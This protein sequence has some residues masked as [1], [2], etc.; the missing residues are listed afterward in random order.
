MDDA[1]LG[2]QLGAAK[3]GA[4][5][6]RPTLKFA[7]AGAV[8]YA[9]YDANPAPSM[10]M[11]NAGAYANPN[12]QLWRGGAQWLGSQPT[13]PY[14]AQAA[15]T[16]PGGV[17]ANI[18]ALPAN[19]KTWYNQQNANA[20]SGGGGGSG[21][22][23]YYNPASA[24]SAPAA[25]PAAAA[26]A[27]AAPAPAPIVAPTSQNIVAPTSTTTVSDPTTTTTGAP[28]LPNSIQAKSYDPNVDATTGAGFANTSNTGGTNYSVGKGDK[29]KQNSA[30]QISG[31]GD[32]ILSRKGGSIT[33]R[34]NRYD[35]GGDVG[36]SAVGMPPG[37]GGQGAIP[38]IY[39]NPATYAG[40]GAPIGKGISQNSVGTTPAGAI[41]SLPMA[42]GGSVAFADGGDVDEYS[43]MPVDEVATSPANA[44]VASGGRNA[45]AAPDPGA[46]PA[47]ASSA[48]SA[49]PNP[50]ATATSPQDV[51]PDLPA[52]TPQVKDADGNPSRGVVGAIAGGLKYLA[53]QLGLGGQ[54]SAI[55]RDPNTSA[56]RQSFA[57][58]QGV[59]G[60]P[61]PAHEDMQQIYNQPGLMACRQGPVR[62]LAW[63]PCA[64][65]ISLRATLTK[66]TRWLHR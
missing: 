21:N 44:D 45:G 58:G 61:M 41:P 32:T 65:F 11:F 14:S 52:W 57:S 27:A 53:S 38:P 49:A 4:I 55:A 5:P 18:D 1:S 36:P 24:P 56:N 2:M 15:E 62:W 29:L 25:T 7:A 30:G 50:Y 33:Q 42:R 20:M 22:A 17:Q 28:G 59:A 23:W 48:Q 46:A 60:A 47:P 19:L 26:P 40:A 54:Q 9:T 51:H 66:P 39:F 64:I 13:S 43:G 10:G 31:A 8:P 12:M 63:K 35:D 6:S 34:V 16:T 37:L 3:G